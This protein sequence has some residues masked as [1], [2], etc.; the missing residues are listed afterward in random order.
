MGGAVMSRKKSAD[1]VLPVDSEHKAAVFR[2]WTIKGVHM[3]SFHASWMSFIVSFMSTFAPAA[4]IPV[5]R[6]DLNLTSTDV[7]SAGIAAVT[8]VISARII[9]GA[10]CDMIGPRY[11]H[12]GLMLLTAPAV[13]GMS[14][15]TNGVEFIICR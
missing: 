10:M 1:F 7:G 13:F 6:E 15:V 12:A 2:P 14:L 4:L 3:T 9:M 5:I 11:G 8:G